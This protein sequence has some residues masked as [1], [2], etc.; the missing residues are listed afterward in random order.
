MT[1]CLSLWWRW[2]FVLAFVQGRKRPW[3]LKTSPQI[4]SKWNFFLLFN[5]FCF[6]DRVLPHS[7]S[8][9]STHNLPTPTSWVLGSWVYTTISS[10]ILWIYYKLQDTE[11]VVIICDNKHWK[12]F[13]CQPERIVPY[14]PAL[15]ST[16]HCGLCAWW[17]IIYLASKDFYPYL[18]F[19]SYSNMSLPQHL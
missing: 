9:P 7:P 1:H 10:P 8:W 13:K 16:E 18:N 3:R 5:L 17:N 12:W 2:S 6:G 4:P 15:W 14:Y 11:Y 19:H